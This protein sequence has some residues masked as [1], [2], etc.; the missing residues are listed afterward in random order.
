MTNEEKVK[1]ILEDF[2]M[3]D[4]GKV[5]IVVNNVWLWCS[6]LSS[7]VNTNTMYFYRYVDT[8]QIYFTAGCISYVLHN[9]RW[10]TN[11]ITRI[12][13]TIQDYSHYNSIWPEDDIKKYINL[14]LHSA[15]LTSTR[16][17]FLISGSNRVKLINTTRCNVTKVKFTLQFW[18]LQPSLDRI[19]NKDNYT[20][21]NSQMVLCGYN[22]L[23]SN[24]TD[25]HAKDAIK[26]MYES[27]YGVDGWEK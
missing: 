20:D 26:L 18:Y 11:K 24:G 19:D 2:R 4:D 7:N 6:R 9:N 27:M 15:R 12:D 22:Y 5:P 21:N 1:M 14:I 25:E 3:S 17:V 16:K 23:K 8:K 10:P 13:K